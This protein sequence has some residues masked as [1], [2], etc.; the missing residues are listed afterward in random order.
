MYKL[1][2]YIMTSHSDE[3]PAQHIEFTLYKLAGSAWGTNK[4][5]NVINNASISMAVTTLV[6]NPFVHACTKTTVIKQP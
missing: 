5:F 1:T 3:L 6:H 2:V 4:N